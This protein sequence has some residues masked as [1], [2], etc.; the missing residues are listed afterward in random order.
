MSGITRRGTGTLL[1]R[2]PGP[3]PRAKEIFVAW[4]CC[5][6]GGG[7]PVAVRFSTQDVCEARLGEV[8]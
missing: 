7:F 1:H 4:S 8:V 6:E 5:F 3:P 2:R